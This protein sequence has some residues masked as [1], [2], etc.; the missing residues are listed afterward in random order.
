MPKNVGKADSRFEA[1]VGFI[2][3]YPTMPL[4]HAMKLA[5]FSVEEQSCRAKHMVLHRLLNKMKGNNNVTPPPSLINVSSLG[6]AASSVS[7]TTGTPVAVEEAVVPKITRI[8][9]S[10]RGAQI[11]RAASLQ[12][13]REYNAAFKRATEM[14]AR[15]REKDD[16][17]SARAVVDTIEKDTGVKLSRRTIQR[18]VSSVSKESV[19]NPLHCRS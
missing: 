16:G 12:Q 1:A 9:L 8:R 14:Y 10:T 17:M 19:R 11:V 4:P 2:K 6:T 13:R 18:K 3:K 15:E 5:D 7:N